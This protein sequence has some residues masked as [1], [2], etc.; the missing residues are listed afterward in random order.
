[1]FLKCFIH[2]WMI[3]LVVIKLFTKL[4]ITNTQ[5]ISFPHVHTIC[6][7][8]L[9]FEYVNYELVEVL[10]IKKYINA[11]NIHK[12]FIFHMIEKNINKLKEIKIHFVVVTIAT[13]CFVKIYKPEMSSWRFML[14][15]VWCELKKGIF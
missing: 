14:I 7:I 9:F 8:A 10:H 2:V 15:L 6:F 13:K 3:F 12:K 1:M 5:T 11:K 4:C